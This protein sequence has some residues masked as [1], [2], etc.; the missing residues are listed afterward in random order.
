M[1]LKFGHVVLYTINGRKKFS[2]TK[3]STRNGRCEHRLCE[4]ASRARHVVVEFGS[5]VLLVDC[6]L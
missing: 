4:R 1:H 3:L 2:C 6:L 5:K